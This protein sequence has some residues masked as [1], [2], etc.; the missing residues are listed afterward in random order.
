MLA[1]DG[2]LSFLLSC[3]AALLRCCLPSV[4]RLLHVTTE[5]ARWLGIMSAS[6][7]GGVAVDLP[8][9]MV[10]YR[11][12]AAGGDAVAMLALG[13]R[14]RLEG[15]HACMS[16]AYYYRWAAQETYAAIHGPEHKSFFVDKT[17]LSLDWVRPD[18]GLE[19]GQ[20]GEDDELIQ[21]HMMQAEAGDVEAMTNLGDLYYYGARGMPRD[22]AASFAHYARAATVGDTAV[23]AGTGPGNSHAWAK[24]ASM[25]MKG[26]GTRENYTA[27][28]LA[29]E[30]A[31]SLDDNPKGHNG[32]AY[33]Y[34]YG[35]GVPQNY[36]IALRSFEAAATQG[37]SDA[38]FNAG[39]MYKEGRG[40]TANTSAAE[41]YFASAAQ[42]GH[43][44][45]IFV[46]HPALNFPH[47]MSVC[48]LVELD[49]CLPWLRVSC[50][51]IRSACTF[52]YRRSWRLIVPRAWCTVLQMLGG[53]NLL[54]E[55]D[56]HA[57]E[58]SKGA[59]YYKIA[60]EY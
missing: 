13:Y 15:P 19:A 6:G 32:L 24:L 38:A 1:C 34:Y 60:G 50:P 28:R 40:A 3:L 10:F 43:V 48:V 41:R 23:A 27:A 53:L 36:T 7:L 55:G 37:N 8:L 42:H 16:S 59:H 57:I 25:H 11:L 12:A 29:F 21:Y 2:S 22:H 20:R 17:R 18:A 9:A 45:A 35:K 56:G 46:R 31:A 49:S 4:S 54:G 26:E 58:C 51:C 5:A 33:L 47:S 39:L 52:I 44:D 14:H 30:K